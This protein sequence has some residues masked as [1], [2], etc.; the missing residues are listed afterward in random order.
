MNDAKTVPPRKEQ[1]IRS[2]SA[3]IGFQFYRHTVKPKMPRKSC[4]INRHSWI[5]ETNTNVTKPQSSHIR[6]NP[7]ITERRQRMISDDSHLV[8]HVSA[9]PPQ[10]GDPSTNE[11]YQHRKRQPQENSQ[12]VVSK[13]GFG[14]WTNRGVVWIGEVGVSHEFDEVV[15]IFE[16][17]AW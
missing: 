4:T 17:V 15:W 7:W 11:P 3:V 5:T 8:V 10:P 12:D 14:R 6:H 9:P 1:T 2:V 16:V 13:L